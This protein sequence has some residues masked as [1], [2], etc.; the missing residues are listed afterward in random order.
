M[1]KEFK[2]GDKVYYPFGGTHI[3]TLD[4]CEDDL[5]YPL[6]IIGE[7]NI[8]TFTLEGFEWN[9]YLLPSIFHA[10]EENHKKLSDLYGVEFEAPPEPKTS[11]EVIQAMLDDGWDVVPVICIEDGEKGLGYA[12]KTYLSMFAKPFNPK[13]GKII[14]DYVN[15]QEIY[16]D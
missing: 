9:R 11:R 6:A 16:E 3:Y 10:T 7:F 13:K 8:E 2:V 5:R 12:S 4:S 1:S 15:G 14:I